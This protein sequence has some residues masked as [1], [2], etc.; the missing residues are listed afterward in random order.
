MRP[1]P[2]ALVLASL[3]G[4]APA[5]EIGSGD[6]YLHEDVMEYYEQ[7][8]RRDPGRSYFA[9]STNGYDVGYSYCPSPGDCMPLDGK[10]EAVRACNTHR[11]DLP[12]ACYIFANESRILWQGEIHVL[13][14]RE[15]IEHHYGPA[16]I[17]E[18]MADYVSRT[19]GPEREAEGPFAPPKSVW[20]QASFHF[21]PAG[22]APQ[23]DECLYAFDRYLEEAVPNY[24]LA[25]E[26]G[27]YC[28]YASG[29]AAGAAAEAYASVAAS[30]AK[31]SPGEAACYV[32]AVDRTVLAGRDGL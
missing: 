5:Q 28:S 17:E 19:K 31:L 3:A 10:I 12:G 6:L 30:C 16:T 11:S 14:A 29:F 23:G 4:T 7:N 8:F 22:F 2:I 26:S 27:R 18:A 15:F 25:D 13:T 24:F 9:V 32:Y 1:L 20:S 21:P